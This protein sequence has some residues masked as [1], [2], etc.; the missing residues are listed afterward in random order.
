[1]SAALQPVLAMPDPPEDGPPAEPITVDQLMQFGR[2]DRADEADLY[3]AMISAARQQIELDTGLSM[4]VQRWG[5]YYA[6]T[7][8]T[9]QG[10]AITKTPLQAVSSVSYMIGNGVST[11]IP[12]DQWMVVWGPTGDPEVQP[13]PG[14][15]WPPAADGQRFLVE[16][17]AGLDPTNAAMP[18]LVQALYVLA[19]HFATAG[20]DLVVPVPLTEVPQ[21]YLAMIQPFVRIAVI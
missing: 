10:L 8:V 17:T 12:D 6:G 5:L 2:I 9:G 13:V 19:A 16:C 20:R 11:E 7:P 14:A 15:S 21:G 18:L 4:I 1:M 3:A